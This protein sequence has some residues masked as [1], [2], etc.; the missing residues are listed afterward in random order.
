MRNQELKNGDFSK[1]FDSTQKRNYWLLGYF[2][3]GSVSVVDAYALAVEMSEV[4]NVPLDTI[5]IDEVLKSRRYKGFKFMYST[6]PDQ[7]MESGCKMSLNN[8]YQWL[9]D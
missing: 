6:H 7:E 3:G 8:V 4:L 5:R 2:G 9:T 1:Y